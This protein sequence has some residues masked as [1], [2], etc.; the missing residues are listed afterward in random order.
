MLFHNMY[1]CIIYHVPEIDF[2][3]LDSEKASISEQVAIKLYWVGILKSVIG[4]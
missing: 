1:M 3:F 4:L 2:F